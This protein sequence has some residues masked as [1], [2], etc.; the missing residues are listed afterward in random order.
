MSTKNIIAQLPGKMTRLCSKVASKGP[1]YLLVAFVALSLVSFA[2]VPTSTVGAAEE[3]IS[4]E[5]TV[6]TTHKCG[7][8]DDA[9][10][11]SIDIGCYGK[12]NA[13]LDATFAIIRLLSTGVGI[14]IVI[15]TIVA[16]IQYATS[17]GD[18]SAV[19][20]AIGRLTNNA[21]ALLI[22]IFGYAILNFIIPAGFFK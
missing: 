3:K 20:K 14:V 22:F 15:S 17:A 21:I 13:L 7:G 18:P 2:A 11:V 8:G 12:G 5:K 10:K 1:V 4:F 16:G 19:Q 9:V 6:V